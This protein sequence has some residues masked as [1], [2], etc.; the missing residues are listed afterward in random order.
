MESINVASSTPSHR[1]QSS[2]Q[3][4]GVT[5]S[6][7]LPGS[8]KIKLTDWIIVRGVS[9]TEIALRQKNSLLRNLSRDWHC[10][11]NADLVSTSGSQKGATEILA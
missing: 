11:H 6:R 1:R 2:S 8:A 4:K 3:S 10:L 5:K 9:Q 7:Q